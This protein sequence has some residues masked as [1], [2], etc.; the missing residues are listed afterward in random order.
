[1]SPRTP[2]QFEQMRE[3]RRESIIHAA[4]Q[5]FAEQGVDRTTISAIARKADISKGLI[6][7]YFDSEEHLLEEVVNAGFSEMSFPVAMNPDRSPSENFTKLMNDL[8]ASIT[9]HK[10]F[11]Q[12][13]AE[14][15]LQ[16]FRNPDLADQF[17]DLYDHFIG[18]FVE[19]FEA[20]KVPG[21][22]IQARK[23]A[24]LLDGIMLHYLFDENYPLQEVYENVVETFTSMMES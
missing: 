11:W 23:M 19:M 21:A 7:N 2:E 22:E 4:L 9:G 15:M 5:L 14:L 3:E 16:I 10:I 13:Y 12:F 17:S 6:Y 18:T 1:M 24:A 8:Y 20:G